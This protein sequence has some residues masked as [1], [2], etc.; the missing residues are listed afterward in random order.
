M[1]E[2]IIADCVIYIETHLNS[3]W[4]LSELA[5]RYHYSPFHFSRLFKE[6]TGVTLAA[7]VRQRRVC[8]TLYEISQGAPKQQTAL[9]YGFQSYSGFYRAFA[10]LCGCGPKD[11]LKIHPVNKP[12]CPNIL[13]RGQ[14]MYTKKELINIITAN[15][16]F[17]TVP[18]LKGL[19]THNKDHLVWSV[20]QHLILKKGQYDELIRHSQICNG[21]IKR[22]ISSQKVCLTKEGQAVSQLAEGNFILMTR[23]KG[24][25]LSIS[26]L[27]SEKSALYA[28]EQGQALA[29]LHQ[30]LKTFDQETVETYD[31]VTTLENWALPETQKVIRQWQL[32]VPDRFFF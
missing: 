1:M 22:G 17:S 19:D 21:L 14:V 8:H 15:W 2:A 6:V 4:T 3:H 30:V 27:F 32:D 29:K 5:E 7:Y 24:L 9:N 16:N 13:E 25:P 23:L 28:K 12:V 10:Q 11:Y 18:S 31:L 26:E 20:N